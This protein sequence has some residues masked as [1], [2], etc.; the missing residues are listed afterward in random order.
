MVYRTDGG[1]LGLAV[2]CT[3]QSV[4]TAVEYGGGKQYCRH[5]WRDLCAVYA[6]LTQAF[7][8][9]VGLSIILMMTT[10]S[11]HPPSGAVAITAVL[12]GETVHQLGYRHIL[13]GVI[14]FTVIVG[15]C[16]R[17]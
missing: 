9:A 3:G 4:G 5:Y 15:D 1:I 10:D 12:G 13:S 2:R 17:V 11:L 6:N 7:S 8:L 16:H 14:K